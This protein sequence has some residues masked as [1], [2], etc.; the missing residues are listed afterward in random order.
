MKYTHIKE[1][2]EVYRDEIRE[3]VYQAMLA[4]KVEQEDWEAWQAA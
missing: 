4:Y 1:V 3:K 2:A